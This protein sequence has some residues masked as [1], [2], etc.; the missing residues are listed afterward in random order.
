MPR[1]D[2]SSSERLVI[3]VSQ[4][5]EAI[6]DGLADLTGN[7]SLGKGFLELPPRTWSCGEPAQHNQTSESL[8]IR[9][10]NRIPVR[11]RILDGGR[12]PRR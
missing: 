9:I 1:L 6:E 2:P 5:T 7:S 8:R 11:N 12:G 3:H 4:F 10:R